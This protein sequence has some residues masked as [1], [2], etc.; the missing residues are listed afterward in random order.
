MESEANRAV[1][2]AQ[3]HALKFDYFMASVALA[4]GGYLLAH[5]GAPRIGALPDMI[6]LA[7]I[8][9]IVVGAACAILRIA[10]YAHTL[11]LQAEAVRLGDTIKAMEE[12]LKDGSTVIRDAL[13]GEI[14]KAA[15]ARQRVE[16]LR[17]QRGALDSKFIKLN[18]VARAQYHA[19]DWLII[20]GFVM[21][22]VARLFGAEIASN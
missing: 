3:E 16:N 17:T 10:N 21:V 5:S 8:L 20:L 22:A 18:R 6:F 11:H 14:L 4:L 9:A 19:R 15:D 12:T 13:T 2:F 7:G 1:E